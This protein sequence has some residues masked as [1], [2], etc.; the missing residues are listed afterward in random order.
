MI[1]D[2]YIDEPSIDTRDLAELRTSLMEQTDNESVVHEMLDDIKAIDVL[3][4]EIGD[5]RFIDG[6]TL[7]ADWNWYGFV[8]EEAEAKLEQGG[9]YEWP[10]N[11]IDWEIARESL[12]GDYKEIMVDGDKYWY[13]KM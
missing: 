3:Q 4:A 6:V 7:V 13:R 1:Q 11:C 12:R 2:Y 9:L 5:K 8:R 10:C